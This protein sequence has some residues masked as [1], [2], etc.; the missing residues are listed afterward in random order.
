M[1]FTLFKNFLFSI[2]DVIHDLIHDLVCDLIPS[3]P[4]FVDARCA[5]A[6]KP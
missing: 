5:E 6:V 3:D 2:C 4:S 1:I